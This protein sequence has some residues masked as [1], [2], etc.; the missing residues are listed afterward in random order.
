MNDDYG[1][2]CNKL[3]ACDVPRICAT[4]MTRHAGDGVH[5][6]TIWHGTR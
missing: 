4:P 1:M 6:N 3:D 2:Q 5:S